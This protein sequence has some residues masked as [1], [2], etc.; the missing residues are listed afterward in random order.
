[1]HLSVQPDYSMINFFSYCDIKYGMSIVPISTG[2]L[3]SLTL[4]RLEKTR[5]IDH[6]Q[7][8]LKDPGSKTAQHS[9]RSSHYSAQVAS[10]VWGTLEESFSITQLTATITNF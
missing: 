3:S 8:Q 4:Y 10:I 7:W 1:M 5:P 9:F 6:G 2:K